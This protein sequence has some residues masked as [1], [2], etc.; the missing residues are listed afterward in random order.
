MSVVGLA[1]VALSGPPATSAAVIVYTLVALPATAIADAET[2]FEMTVTNVAGPDDL[3]CLEV[4]LPAEYEIY[5]VSDP[6]G[7]RNRDWSSSSEGNTVV[8]WSESGGG[9]LRILESATFTIVARSKEAG[10]SMWSNHAHRSQGCDDSEAIGIP[11]EVIVLPPL[12]T[13]TPVPT[14]K[15]TPEPT[16]KPTPVPTARPTPAPTPQPAPA[17]PRPPVVTPT[18]VPTPQADRSPSIDTT[19]TPEPSPGAAPS[20]AAVPPG[21]SPPSD[22]GT[23]A[24]Q[25]PF[26][27]EEPQGSLSLAAASVLA[28]VSVFAVPAAVLGGPG[29]LLILFVALQAV[30]ALGWIPAVRR[31][32]GEDSART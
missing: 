25:V 22:P 13:P 27:G 17:T 23:G 7:P 26:R 8:V 2:A 21:S 4:E 28:G 14:A 29:L 10:V 19:E 20:D 11:V 3:G 24:V 18:P 12:P 6:I 32:R 5:S 1:F 15:P 31:L 9:R 30:G 16:P